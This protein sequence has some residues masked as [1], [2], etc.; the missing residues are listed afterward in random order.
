MKR[1][2]A[3]VLFG[4]AA[5]PAAADFP[6]AVAA[7]DGGDYAAAFAESVAEAGRGDADAQYLAGFLYLRGEGVRRD[8]VRAYMWFTL[9]ARQGDAIAAD[10]LAGL[11]REMTADQIAEAEALARDW[12]PSV[13]D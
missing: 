8:P 4:F 7:Y 10:A 9:A 12:L 13:T 2:A 11:A 5:A 1:F 3:A 6:A